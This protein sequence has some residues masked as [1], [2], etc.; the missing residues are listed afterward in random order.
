[1]SLKIRVVYYASILRTRF[2]FHRCHHLPGVVFILFDLRGWS[3]YVLVASESEP[4]ESH[5]LHLYKDPLYCQG[6]V[7]R[8]ATRIENGFDT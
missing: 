1:M 7:R 2:V 8:Q 3:V 4:Y 5:I 6:H